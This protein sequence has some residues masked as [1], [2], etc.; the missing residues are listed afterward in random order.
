MV[1]K[2]EPQQCGNTAHFITFFMVN[3]SIKAVWVAMRYIA[4]DGVDEIS[5]RQ[6]LEGPRPAGDR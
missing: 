3:K 5:R 2:G 6:H 1:L 4:S